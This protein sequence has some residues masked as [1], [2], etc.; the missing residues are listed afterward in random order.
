ME[1]PAVES[2]VLV[3]HREPDVLDVWYLAPD[4]AFQVLLLAPCVLGAHL[5]IP[6]WLP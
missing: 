3:T 1:S 4:P 6:F 5:N 2:E